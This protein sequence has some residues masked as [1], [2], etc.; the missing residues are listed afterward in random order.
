MDVL[1]TGDS[2][3]GNV[4][5]RAASIFAGL[6]HIATENKL[7]EIDQFKK[8]YK[9]ETKSKYKERNGET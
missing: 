6:K 1:R 4:E 2:A 7:V 3:I 9:V 8:M 5:N